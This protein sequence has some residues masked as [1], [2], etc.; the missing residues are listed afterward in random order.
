MLDAVRSVRFQR[1]PDGFRRW[2]A[3]LP[4][5]ATPLLDFLQIRQSLSAAAGFS[6]SLD[7]RGM[8]LN[9]RRL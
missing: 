3:A 5:L 1:L 7:Y 9:G 8:R 4:I 2:S 6:A